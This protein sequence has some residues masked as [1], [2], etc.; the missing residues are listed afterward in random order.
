MNDYT[1]YLKGIQCKTYLSTIINFS[2]KL[3]D[4]IAYK[5]KLLF[6][7]EGKTK[8]KKEKHTK[9]KS[10]SIHPKIQNTLVKWRLQL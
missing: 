5:M 1:L 9:P 8:G 6:F 10:T 2:I 7:L 4:E 3:Q